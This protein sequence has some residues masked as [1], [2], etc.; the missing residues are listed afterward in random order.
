MKSILVSVI[1][2]DE[3][4]LNMKEISTQAKVVTS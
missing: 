2:Q 3:K 1:Q 4:R